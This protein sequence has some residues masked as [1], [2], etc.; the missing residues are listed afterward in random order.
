[1]TM[2]IGCSRA[3]AT[4]LVLFIGGYVVKLPSPHSWRTFLWGLLGNMQERQ[5]S[6][7]G[8]DGLCPVIFA[9]PGGFLNVMP[10]ARPMTREEW[11]SFDPEQFT[12]RQDYII[13]AE[14]KMDSFGWLDG[15]VV[16]IDYGS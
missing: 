14:H 8:W 4:R 15:R 9:L 16:A 10:R 2:R 3:G 13:P 6:R 7:C 12:N 11:F 1:M 5:F